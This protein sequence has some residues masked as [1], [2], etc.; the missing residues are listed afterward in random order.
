MKTPDTNEMPIIH[1]YTRAEAIADG[2]LVDVTPTAREAGLTVPVAVTAAVHAQYVALPRV[3]LAGQS[4][5]GRLWD[6][7]Y[8]LVA[9]IA[10][11][12][13]RQRPVGSELRFQLYVQN[14]PGR[15]PQPVTLKAHSGPGDHG[16][17]VVTVMLPEED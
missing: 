10:E 9:H 11:L 7:L 4:E 5:D 1:S 17:H 6:I 8:M 2:V 14:D 13:M 3:D 15:E 12:R 16:E